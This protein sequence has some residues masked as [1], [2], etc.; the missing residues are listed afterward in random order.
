MVFMTPFSKLHVL[1][2]AQLFLDI[3]LVWIFEL[4]ACGGM[5]TSLVH[6][7]DKSD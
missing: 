4:L 7:C 6:C 1:I 3:H 2:P 5:F